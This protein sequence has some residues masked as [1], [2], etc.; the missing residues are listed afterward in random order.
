MRKEHLTVVFLLLAIASFARENEFNIGL[1]SM[2]MDYREYNLDGS[3]ADSEKTNALTGLNLNYST[4]ISDADYGASSLFDIDFSLYQGNTRYDGFYID[5]YDGHITGPANNLTTKNIISD[6]SI[7]YSEIKQLDRVIWNTRFGIG[8]RFWERALE[9]THTEDY[10]WLYGSIST[11]ISGNIFTNNNI[12]IFAEY[13][14][15]FSP[16]MESNNFGTFDLGRTDGYSISLPWTHTISPSW[17]FKFD[18]TYKTWNIEH[19]T[20]HSDN[21]YEPD[22]ESKFHTVSA[23]LVYR[24]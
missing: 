11:G 20:K 5:P 4:Q 17:A 14:R 1:S 23:A 12:G 22:S 19:S 13:H 9:D 6:S 18:Y 15:A 3:F 10:S 7:G 24:Y 2:S 8:Y 21:R 16:K